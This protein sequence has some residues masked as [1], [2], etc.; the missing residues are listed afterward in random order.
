MYKQVAILL[1]SFL[2]VTEQSSEGKAVPESAYLDEDD[3]EPTHALPDK[4][5][6]FLA[7]ATV[8]GYR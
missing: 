5:D 7:Y 6:M 3:R 1:I 8:P 2:I 4:A